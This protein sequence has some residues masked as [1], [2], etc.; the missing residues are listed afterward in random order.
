MMQHKKEVMWT[1]FCPSISSQSGLNLT[2]AYLGGPEF[3]VVIYLWLE[4]FLA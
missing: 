3:I 1:H 4:P 2:S